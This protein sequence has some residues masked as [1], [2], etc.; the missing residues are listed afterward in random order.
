[1]IF[2]LF[3]ENLH[4]YLDLDKA[5]MKLLKIILAGILQE[6]DSDKIFELFKV[7]INKTFLFPC[8]KTQCLGCVR[9]FEIEDVQRKFKNI[10]EPFPAATTKR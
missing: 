6:L 8:F 5:N 1:M 7:L 10:H 4:L 2:G 9:R 3:D